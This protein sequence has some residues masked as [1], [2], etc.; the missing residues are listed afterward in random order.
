MSDVRIIDLYNQF[1]TQ[2]VGSGWLDVCVANS[3]GR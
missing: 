3:V 1:Q 2:L